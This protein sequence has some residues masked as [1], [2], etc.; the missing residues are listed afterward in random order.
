MIGNRADLMM[1]SCMLRGR[2][3]S[4]PCTMAEKLFNEARVFLRMRWRSIKSIQCF[5]ICSC[6]FSD[7][8]K[9]SRILISDVERP[10]PV[11]SGRGGGGWFGGEATI[12]VWS[13]TEFVVALVAAGVS[14]SCVSAVNIV[15]VIS[16]EC[17]SIQSE[18]WVNEWVIQ[19]CVVPSGK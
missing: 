14:G 8:L 19:R 16:C 2:L 1:F 11:V 9:Q 17:A 13:G 12:D 10:G 18:R 7:A 6:V 3:P 4:D 5:R 15:N